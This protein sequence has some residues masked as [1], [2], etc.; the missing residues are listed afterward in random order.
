MASENFCEPATSCHFVLVSLKKKSARRSEVRLPED[1]STLIETVTS[2]SKRIPCGSSSS[3]FDAAV[4]PAS[5]FGNAAPRSS[6]VKTLTETTTSLVSAPVGRLTP[7]PDESSLTTPPAL[8]TNFSTRALCLTLLLQSAPKNPS[9]HA[10]TAAGPIHRGLSVF[11]SSSH[12]RW[13]KLCCGVTP[14]DDEA[15]DEG[16]V[17][18]EGD[19]EA[20]VE[21]MVEAVV[22][23]VE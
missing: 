19:A 9:R 5:A 22:E 8:P 4:K 23:V 7:D 3:T 18:I 14:D 17:E 20:E 15:E 1:S 2:A 12:V 11:A 6:R 16:Y 21:A 13:S 10:H